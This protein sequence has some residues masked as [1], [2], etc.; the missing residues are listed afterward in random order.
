M[1]LEQIQAEWKRGRRS[2]EAA[3]A[4][5][6]QGF[7]ED[8]ISRAYYGVMYGA[9]AALLL[10]D[11]AA[12]SHAAVRRLFGQV[13]IKTGELEKEWAGILAHEQDQRVG[14]DYNSDFE[15]NA[16]DAGELVHDARRFV[17]R[18]THYLTSKGL[19]LE[20]ER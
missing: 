8:A 11:V 16:E 5:L 12:K 10:H 4:L 15:V 20:E 14:A 7:L 9:R 3:E 2:L 13:L 1:R 19:S 18:I 6:V 17:E